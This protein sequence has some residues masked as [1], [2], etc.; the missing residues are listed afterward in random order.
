MWHFL[1]A[2]I[3]ITGPSKGGMPNGKGEPLSDLN[4]ASSCLGANDLPSRGMVTMDVRFSAE[5]GDNH[6]IGISRGVESFYFFFAIILDR[7]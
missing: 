7:V 6:V 3:L 2:L 1:W 5:F 4:L